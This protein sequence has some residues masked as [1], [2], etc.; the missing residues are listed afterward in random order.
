MILD[1]YLYLVY[2]NIKMVEGEIKDQQQ[3]KW[4]DF[5]DG[6][7]VAR[8]IN[9]Q[10]IVPYLDQL[11]TLINENLSS[12]FTPY[13]IERLSQTT[14]HLDDGRVVDESKFWAGQ[15]LVAELNGQIVA[16]C[17][18]KREAVFN[19]YGMPEETHVGFIPLILNSKSVR[20]QKL[21]LFFEL[22][23]ARLLLESGV[24]EL[25]GSTSINSHNIDAFY[26]SFAT[27]RWQEG[28][29]YR[30]IFDTDKIFDTSNSLFENIPHTQKAFNELKKIN[31]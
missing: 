10:Q 15:T 30:Y 13:S 1:K 23:A 31:A 29:W 21:A 8:I 7:R 25:R 4:V 24:T 12:D 27:K 19:E 9:F 17:L 5:K 3:I 6:I 16:V 11:V 28:N 14:R 2:L 20:G 18:A 22:V 26:S